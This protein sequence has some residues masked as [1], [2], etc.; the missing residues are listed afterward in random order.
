MKKP[1]TRLRR[2]SS[3]RIKA[4]H[5][6]RLIGQGFHKLKTYHFLLNAAGSFT[7][8]FCGLAGILSQS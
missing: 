7:G 6:K 2:E 3:S 8:I 1:I 4:I 5:A